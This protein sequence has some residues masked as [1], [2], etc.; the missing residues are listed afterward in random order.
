MVKMTIDPKLWNLL[1]NIAGTDQYID[2]SPGEQYL[3]MVHISDVC[4]AYEKAFEHLISNTFVTNDVYGIYPS[5][6]RQLKSIIELFAKVL[7]KPINVH[8][9]GKSYKEREVMTPYDG[10]KKLPNWE[11]MIDLEEGLRK[12][13]H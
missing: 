8:F 4:I 7:D 6:R 5:N 3:Y 1:K 10:Y 11:P 2:V 13:K 9:G 12:F